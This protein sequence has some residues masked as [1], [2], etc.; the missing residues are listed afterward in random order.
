MLVSALLPIQRGSKANR[1]PGGVASK[2]FEKTEVAF[3]SGK[4]LIRIEDRL[5]GETP[6]EGMKTTIVDRGHEMKWLFFLY[7]F[8]IITWILIP[9]KLCGACAHACS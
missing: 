2:A 7:L 6:C 9:Q 5:G 1:F 3:S 8:S 4:N